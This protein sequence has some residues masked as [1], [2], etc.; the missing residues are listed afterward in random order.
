MDGRLVEGE[1]G[2]HFLCDRECTGHWA[3]YPHGVEAW[4][5]AAHT[6]AV[7]VAQAVPVATR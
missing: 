7:N 6:E 3:I 4:S 5:V 2:A 1:A